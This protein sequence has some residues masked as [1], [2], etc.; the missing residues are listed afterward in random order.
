MVDGVVWRRQRAVAAGIQRFE[1][2]IDVDF[3]SGLQNVADSPSTS[4]T[5]QTAISDAQTLASELNAAGSQY[6][7]LRSSVN[8]QL[9]DTVSQIN[10][11]TAQIGTLNQ[12]INAYTTYWPFILGVILIVLLFAFPGGIVGALQSAVARLRR[13]RDA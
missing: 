4:A 6:D 2:I 5:R 10:T 13:R 7:Q 8:T 1:L 11:Y 12:Q 9:S 3:F